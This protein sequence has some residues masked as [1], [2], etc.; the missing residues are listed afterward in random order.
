[1]TEQS[2]DHAKDLA[3]YLLKIRKAGESF[4]DFVQFFRPEWVIPKFHHK[5]ALLLD[6][7][8]KDQLYTDF[9]DEFQRY[10]TCHERR[11]P[12]HYERKPDAQKIHNAMVNMPPRHSKSSYCTEMFPAYYMGRNPSRYAMTT[13][14]NSDLASGFGRSVQTLIEDPKF[15]QIFPAFALNARATAVDHWRTSESGAYYSIGVGGTTSGRPATLLIIDDPVKSRLEAE[16]LTQRNRVWDFYTS[17]LTTRLQPETNGVHPKQLVILTRWHPDDLGGRIQGTD[18]W[19]DGEWLHINFKAI[20][21]TQTGVKKRRDQLPPEHPK[22]CPPENLK[23]KS[24]KWAYTYRDDALWPERFP[25]DWLLKKRKLNERDFEALYQQNPYIKG[26][27]L[28]KETWWQYYETLPE[29]SA[30]VIAADTAFKA[31]QRSDYSVFIVAGICRAGNYYLI[32]LHRGRWEFPQ[33]KRKLLQLNGMFRSQGLRGF[34]VEDK[35]SG[36]SLIQEMRRESGVVIIPYKNPSGDKVTRANL[37]TPFIESG[38]V[39]LPKQSTWLDEFTLECSQFPNNTHDDQVD[40][41]CIALD[42]LSRFA[43]PNF[44]TTGTSL[45]QTIKNS[46]SLPGAE[47]L[48]ASRNVVPFRRLGN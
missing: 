41:L 3:Q 14:Y 16:S 45:L 21:E 43:T 8:E 4:I 36:Q 37:V 2:K 46:T 18:E 40:A 47:S 24:A 27:N 25:L 1:M 26:G 31:N 22:Y 13:A 23:S 39:Y 35:A 33:L 44:S 15:G 12:F 42:T 34:Y 32:D 17:A 7:M 19:Q 11:I 28:I 10:W 48:N 29:L 38:L 20:Q 30:I 9:E 6:R 5:L